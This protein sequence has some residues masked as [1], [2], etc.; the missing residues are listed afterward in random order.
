LN[1]K[2]YDDALKDVKKAQDLGFQIHPAVL[3][4]LRGKR[5]EKGDGLK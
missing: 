1:K 3:K 2:K 5:G 4:A